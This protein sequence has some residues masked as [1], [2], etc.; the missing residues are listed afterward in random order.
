MPY[1]NPLEFNFIVNFYEVNSLPGA[2]NTSI[3]LF[4]F[5]VIAGSILG[6]AYSIVYRI[7]SSTGGSDFLTIYYSNKTN[8][9]IGSINRNVNLIIL[10][11]IIV[12]NTIILPVSLIN[13]D[14]KMSVLKGVGVEEAYNSGLLEQMWNFAKA[15]NNERPDYN[16]TNIL[17]NFNSP[18]NLM[19]KNTYDY[20]VEYICKNKFDGDLSAGLVAKMKVLF[21]F[22]PS[23]FSSIVLVLTAGIT[24]N[25]MYP[26]FKIRTFMMATNKPKDINKLL[27]EKGYQNDILNWDATNRISGN[28]LHRSV[29]MVAMTVLNWHQIEREVFLKDPE[30]K[31]T[32]LKTK[33]V[34]G[35]FKYDIKNNEQRDTVMH[36]VRNNEKELE[37]IKQIAIVRLNKENEKLN[38][39]LNKKTGKS[40]KQQN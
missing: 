3:W 38:K 31:V 29:V 26:K 1:I 21:I 20:L 16:M 2:F 30:I 5:A 11:T 39:R 15:A 17:N 18:L 37:K 8:K 19:D 12:L 6:V 10:G 35:I 13:S 23:L 40:K 7:G 36:K 34:K 33:K 32:I 28:Y 25:T 9:S 14:I 27:V 24:T 22:G 4:I